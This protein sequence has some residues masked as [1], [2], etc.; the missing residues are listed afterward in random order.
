MNENELKKYRLY[1][2]IGY[3][4]FNQQ[5]STY[6]YVNKT[7]THEHAYVIYTSPMFDMWTHRNAYHAFPLYLKICSQRLLYYA[8]FSVCL[9]AQKNNMLNTHL[10]QYL[11]TQ[12]AL[13]PFQ[14]HIT[15]R[16]DW[17]VR[18]ASTRHGKLMFNSIWV[19]RWL[20]PEAF[21]PYATHAQ[22]THSCNRALHEDYYFVIYTGL[23]APKWWVR[24]W[25]IGVGCY[26]NAKSLPA[27]E[28]HH[29]QTNTPLR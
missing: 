13:K 9:S 5:S 10:I 4:H 18:T 14:Q 16:S 28:P 1:F 3:F 15:S 19:A 17:C 23:C 26:A 24:I 8:T 7:Y 27:S 25:M 12:A 20:S 6:Q 22:I 29:D 21:I 11:F 2:K